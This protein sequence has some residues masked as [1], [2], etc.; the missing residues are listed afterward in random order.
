MPTSLE[1]ANEANRPKVPLAQLAGAEPTKLVGLLAQLAAAN[2]GATS[3]RRSD[4]LDSCH[5][6]QLRWHSLPLV[7]LVPLAPFKLVRLQ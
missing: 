5:E 1:I 2:L 4:Q 3:D 7:K 6:C